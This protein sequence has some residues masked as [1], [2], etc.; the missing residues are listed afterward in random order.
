MQ[1]RQSKAP[2]A[3]LWRCHCRVY[4]TIASG[5]RSLSVYDDAWQFRRAPAPQHVLDL[6]TDFVSAFNQG[7]RACKMSILIGAGRVLAHGEHG[8]GAGRVVTHGDHSSRAGLPGK[9]RFLGA[10]SARRRFAQL[11]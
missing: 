9:G 4:Q 2:R 11:Q 3:A 6:D 8:S 5:P 10:Q 1:G 7:H